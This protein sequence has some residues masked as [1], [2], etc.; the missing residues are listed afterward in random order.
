[1]ILWGGDTVEEAS[2]QLPCRGHAPARCAKSARTSPQGRPMWHGCG[3]AGGGRAAG[4]QAPPGRPPACRTIDAG[5]PGM[6]R[7]LE[8]RMPEPRVRMLRLT[9]PGACF[10]VMAAIA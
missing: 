6:G 4:E 9:Y 7:A 2:V 10:V 1:M 5:A 3:F 8:A